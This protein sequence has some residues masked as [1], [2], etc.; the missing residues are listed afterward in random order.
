[1][2]VP[3]VPVTIDGVEYVAKFPMYALLSAERE[4]GRSMTRIGRDMSMNDMATIIKHGLHRDGKPIS[5][6]EFDKILNSMDV[7]DFTTLGK[8]ISPLIFPQQ[9]ENSAGKN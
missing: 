3:E 4:L 9:A 1:M 7:S 8:Q 2:A 5:S 6:T